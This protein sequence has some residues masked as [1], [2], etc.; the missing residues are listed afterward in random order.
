MN[1]DTGKNLKD[2][3]DFV[4]Y[5]DSIDEGQIVIISSYGSAYGMLDL[6]NSKGYKAL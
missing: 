2:A 1:F 6:H 3:H 4:Q 5:V